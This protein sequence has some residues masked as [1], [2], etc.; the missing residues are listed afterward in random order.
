MRYKEIMVETLH[1]TNATAIIYHPT[2]NIKSSLFRLFVL[3]YVA[4]K[5]VGAVQGGELSI[6]T[7]VMT[8]LRPLYELLIAG[9]SRR[10]AKMQA[11]E[12][13]F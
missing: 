3:Y 1:K 4:N 9:G 7:S 6:M 10:S 2:C 5:L 13:C 8:S 12:A 11:I